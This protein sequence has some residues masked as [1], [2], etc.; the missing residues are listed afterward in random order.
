[1]GLGGGRKSVWVWVRRYFPSGFSATGDATSAQ[2]G[3]YFNSGGLQAGVMSITPAIS[4]TGSQTV[5]TSTQYLNG[6]VSA[7]VVDSGGANQETLTY[8]G[9]GTAPGK[10]TVNSNTS[11]TA[12]FTKTHPA[13]CTCD[14]NFGNNQNNGF[15]LYPGAF[16]NFGRCSLEIGNG[17]GMEQ[18]WTGGTGSNLPTTIAESYSG[19]SIGTIFSSGA[20]HEMLLHAEQFTGVSGNTFIGI[21]QWIRNIGDTT[22]TRMGYRRVQDAG[23]TLNDLFIEAGAF[24]ANYNQSRSTTLKFYL[25]GHSVWDN[26]TNADPMGVLAHEATLTPEACTVGSVTSQTGTT[27]TFPVTLGRYAKY[28]RPVIDGTEDAGQEY[29]IPLEVGDVRMSDNGTSG[30]NPYVLSQT[31]T[32]MTTAAHTISFNVY[33]GNKSAHVNTGNQSVTLVASPGALASISNATAGLSAGKTLTFPITLNASGSLPT[34]IAWDYSTDGGTTWTAGTDYTL[35]NP[36]LGQS[37]TFT[38]S[39]LTASTAYSIRAREKNGAGS[40][41]NSATV[42]GTTTAGETLPTTT[43]ALLLALESTNCDVST[44]GASIGSITDQS[45]SGVH[46]LQAA[47][48]AQPTLVTGA[49]TNGQPVVRFASGKYLAA[50]A[51]NAAMSVDNCMIFVVA[52]LSTSLST[53]RVVFGN[54]T[55]TSTGW[56]EIISA[57]SNSDAPGMQLG[58]TFNGQGARSAT[59]KNYE[60]T[61]SGSGSFRTVSTWVDGVS[62]AGG[63]NNATTLNTTVPI[64]LGCDSASLGTLTG[65]FDLAAVY[66]VAGTNSTDRTNVETFIRTKWGTT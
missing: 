13:A 58:T 26:A 38:A 52:S 44:N 50:A 63:L 24:P 62:V 12:N 45:A 1:M 56:A 46:V 10:F 29:A 49:T 40:S 60:T 28:I 14:V 7:L 37:T 41:S 66:I 34:L 32:G 9:V 27:A 42:T 21:N 25:W 19:S 18:L 22:Y 65:P 15:K 57:S 17:T 23:T 5:A 20:W 55:T 16:T 31:I 33:N 61:I 36:S 54:R 53:H 8:D 30:V 39:G 6:N 35:S 64:T 47:G 11:I 51:Y 4:S 59:I 43:G 3:S 48:T 2:W